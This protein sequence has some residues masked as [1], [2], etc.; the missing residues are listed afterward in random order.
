MTSASARAWGLAGALCGLVFAADQAAKAAVEANL[1]PGEQV[2]LLGPLGL[3]LTHNRGV[4]FGLAGGAGV[5]LVLLTAAALCVIG[6]LFSRNP[7]RPGMWVAVGLLAGGAVG[8]LADRVRADAVTDFV[9]VG[10]WPAF[11]LADVWITVGVV[12]LVLFYFQD[13]EREPESG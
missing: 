7:T 1:V 8:N 3:T 13:A 5:K 9:D 10:S 6:Y 2:D 11:N 12:L 4:A